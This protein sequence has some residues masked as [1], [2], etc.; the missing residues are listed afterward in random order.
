MFSQITKLLQ[1]DYSV[2]VKFLGFLIPL[3]CL[4]YLIKELY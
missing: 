1:V 4:I 3:E 2:V